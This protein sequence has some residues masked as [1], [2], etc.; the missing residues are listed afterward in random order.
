[1]SPSALGDA[2]H[3]RGNAAEVAAPANR[4][5][6]SEIISDRTE[7]KCESRFKYLNQG[8]FTGSVESQGDSA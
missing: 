3:T 8:G 7:R 4:G 6:E 5:G 2:D 1:M